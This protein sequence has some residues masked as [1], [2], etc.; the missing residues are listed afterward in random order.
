MESRGDVMDV[1][2]SRKLAI[3]RRSC[4]QCRSRKVGCDRGSPCSNCVSAKL[5]CTFGVVAS[6]ATTAKQRVL[7]SAQY[8]QKI[9]DIADEL[10]SIKALLQSFPVSQ[11]REKTVLRVSEPRVVEPLTPSDSYVDTL[12]ASAKFDHS[13]QVNEFVRTVAEDRALRECPGAEES[14][15]LASLRRLARAL[16]EPNVTR[17][18][19]FLG[20]PCWLSDGPKVNQ[21]TPLYKGFFRIDSLSRILPL[22][23]FTDICQKVY[24]AVE[25]Y[26]QF[27]FILAN[28]YLSYV[29]SEYVA[30]TGKHRYKEYH[31]QCRLNAQVALSQLPLLLPATTEAVAT[32][33]FG[34]SYAIE[35]SRATLA[36][37]YISNAANLCQT[38][39]LHRLSNPQQNSTGSSQDPRANLFWLVFLLDKSLAL[40]LGR[41]ST[42]RDAEVTTPLP[43]HESM[44]RCSQTSMIQGR[45]YEDLYSP[46]GLARPDLERS[47]CAQTLATELRAL[48]SENKI[49]FQIPCSAVRDEQ[50]KMRDVYFRIELVKQLSL[51]TLILRAVPAAE[52]AATSIT[53]ECAAAARETLDMHQDCMAAAIEA[54][55]SDQFMTDRYL[56]WGILHTPFVPF[57]VLFTRCVQ[58]SDVTDLYYLERFSDSLRL[59]EPLAESITHPYRLYKLLCQAAGLYIKQAP[60]PPPNSYETDMTTVDPWSVF[61][62]AS[63]ATE[64]DGGAYSQGLDHNISQDLSHWFYGNQQLMGLLDDD[65]MF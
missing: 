6:K 24:F 22:E 65:I 47:V 36:W 56:H 4:D 29:F 59:G 14:D 8:E 12:R 3:P 49:A 62:F 30:V 16:E 45:I 33:A 48:I 31:S 52:G 57:S 51:L 42:L 54:N 17:G 28:C 26:S 34:A 18:A 11:E 37:T 10:K 13:S 7:I 43:I 1:N 32:L 58:L 9:D 64:A 44:K 23:R 46:R 39:G 53:E 38:L 20:S 15:I 19:S 60:P 50:D 5:T 63:F 40:R 35:S 25:D 61:D 2:S 41:P 55:E 21:P 27:D